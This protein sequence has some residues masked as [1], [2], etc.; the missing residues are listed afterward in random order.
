MTIPVLSLL[1]NHLW[2]STI[3]AGIAWLLALALRKNRAAVR[4][5]IWFA[6]SVKFLIPLSLLI[7]MGSH[8]QWRT[9]PALVHPQVSLAM[10]RIS[11]PFAASTSAPL[12]PIAPAPANPVPA[13]LVGV[14]LCG[15]ALGVVF[16][17]SRFQRLRSV[18]R[19]ATPIDLDLSIRAFSSRERLEPGVAGIFRPVLLLPEGIWDRLTPEQL[20]AIIAHELRHVARRDNITAAIHMLVET[21]FWFHPATWWIRRR[22]IE[23]RECACDQEVLEMGGEPLVYAEGILR[24]CKQYLASPAPYAAGVSGGKLTRR[25]EMIVANRLASNLTLWKKLALCAAAAVAIIFPLA[26]GA[27]RPEQTPELQFE[28]ASIRPTAFPSDAYAAGVRAARASNPCEGGKLSVSGTRVSLTVA[29]ICDI[30][31]I[32]YDVRSYQVTGVPATLGLSGQDKTAPFPVSVA[33]ATE[34]KQPVFFYDIEARAPGP[35]LPSE[36]QVREML[37]SLLRDRFHLALHRDNKEISFYA[38]VPAKNG[39]RL[40]PSA[41]GCKPAPIT[42]EMMRVCGQTMEQV[43]QSLNSYT[44]R[45][46]LDMTGISTRFD[47][48]IPIDRS[49]FGESLLNGIQERLK[50][51]LEPRKGPVEVLVVDHVERPSEN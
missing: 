25:I 13:I 4:Y 48:E 12:P 30:I 9:A 26:V 5:W 11:Q 38:L 51:K 7:S 2:Q 33:I 32:A 41:D 42:S 6:A 39:P 29:G 21:I 34:A 49:N 35:N 3:F 36:E 40:N 22:L 27:V 16:W 23:E 45:K 24:V 14:W 15:I 1:A 8:L 37:R 20:A 46:V 50:L 18:M 10:E 43:A 31:R 19:A 44:D 47:Y 28:V 17:V